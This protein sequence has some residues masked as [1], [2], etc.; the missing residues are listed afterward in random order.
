ML[1]A[2]CALRNVITIRQLLSGRRISKELK[3]GEV[4]LSKPNRVSHLLDETPTRSGSGTLQ[5]INEYKSLWEKENYE[6]D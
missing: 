3:K 6:Q 1:N 4:K 2:C 5:M